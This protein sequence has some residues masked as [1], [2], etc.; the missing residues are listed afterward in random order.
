MFVWPD[1]AFALLIGYLFGSVPFGLI[2]VWLSGGGDVRKI[3]S[4]SIGATNVLRT[5]NRWAAAATLLFDAAKGAAAVLISAHYF[6]ETGAIA[7]AIGAT[8]GHLFPVWLG[9]KGGK[10]VA[11]S[12]GILLALYWP[13]ALLALGTWLVAVALFRIS[14]LAALVAAFTTPLYMLAFGLTDY[15]FA[16]LII[17]V[18]VVV[19]HRENIRRLTHGEEPKIGKSQA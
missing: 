15:A 4:H 2:F 19:M 18:L 10:G 8:L 13:V 12:L 3:G 14:S 17:A 1:S 7:A 11:V 6:G 5:G 16:T 9:F